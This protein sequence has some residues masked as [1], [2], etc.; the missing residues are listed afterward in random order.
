MPTSSWLSTSN[1]WDWTETLKNS[2]T[3]VEFGL[4]HKN[5]LSSL[6]LIRVTTYS[7][8]KMSDTHSRNMSTTAQNSLQ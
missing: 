8:Q 6:S 1:N 2:S 5:E 7:K 4:L 3:L